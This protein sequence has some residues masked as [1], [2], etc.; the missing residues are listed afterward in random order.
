MRNMHSPKVSRILALGEDMK[1]SDIQYLIKRDVEHDVICEAL[2][3]SSNEF[4]TLLLELSQSTKKSNR[5]KKPFLTMKGNEYI[6]LCAK[7]LHDEEIARV[8]GVSIAVLRQWKTKNKVDISL[9]LRKA[10]L[11]QLQYLANHTSLRRLA[12][13]EFERREKDVKSK[14]VV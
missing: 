2:N 10:N 4:K 8:K 3:M 12:L 9:V 1:T 14:S 6:N 5:G 11:K 7:Y 13:A